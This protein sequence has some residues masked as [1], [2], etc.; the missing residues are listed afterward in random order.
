M[1]SQITPTASIWNY[2][3]DLPTYG[4]LTSD[5]RIQVAVV[6]AGIAGLSTAYQL[7]KRGFRVAVIDDGPI[8][9]GDTGMTTA[10]VTG[11]LDKG[12]A[13]TA[14]LRGEAGARLAATSHAAAIDEIERIVRDEA[15]ACDFTRMDGYLFLSEGDKLRSLTDEHDAANRAGLLD[16]ELRAV[17]VALGEVHLGP[18]L[19]FPRQAHFHP[20]KYLA[21]LCRAIERMGGQIFCG[22]HVTH[23]KAGPLVTLETAGRVV[24]QADHVV[25]ATHM[26]INDVL[27][28]STRVFPALTYVIGLRIPKGSLPNFVAFDTADPYHYIRIQSEE[29]HDVL[30]V[31]GEDHKTG[32]ADDMDARY[33]RLE[34]WARAHFPMVGEVRYAWSGQVANSFDGLALI[35]PDLVSENVYVITGQTGIGMTHSTIGSLIIADQIAGTANLWAKLY[36]PARAPGHGLGEVISEGLNV[37]SQYTDLLKGGDVGSASEIPAGSGAVIGW[38]PSKVAT[39]RDPQGALHRHSALC[40]HLGCVVAWNDSAKTWDCPCHGS[41]FDPYG[42]VMNGPASSDLSQDT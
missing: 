6:G 42:K 19:R 8:G 10:Q 33:L 31:G 29:D 35:G 36:A 13:E 24:V 9:G 32:Q 41:R 4:P 23:L 1:H 28:Y 34:D 11:M 12:Y 15:I 20:L 3:A 21:G 7:A 14:K 39:Y 30:I 17:D 5:L 27:G 22:T 40:T 37:L 26:P 2:D 16:V 18:A 38:G 25:L